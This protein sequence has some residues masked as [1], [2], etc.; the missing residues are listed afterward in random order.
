MPLLFYLPFWIGALWLLIAL[1]RWQSLIKYWQQ[2][3]SRITN[4]IAIGCAIGL[5]IHFS[6]KIGIDAA[7]GL[8]TCTFVLKIVEAR[9]I[10]DGQLIIFIGFLTTSTHFLLLQTIAAAFYALICCGFLISSWRRLYL[11]RNKSMKEIVKRNVSVF[12]QVVPIML[13]LFLLI[14][15]FPPLWTMPGKKTPT[16]GFSEQLS[17]GDLSQLV[18]NYEAAFR[19]SFTTETRPET[20]E[21]Y[22]RGF[23]LDKFDGRTW[24]PT[25]KGSIIKTKKISNMSSSLLSYEI[26][27]EPHGYRWLFSLDRP[28]RIN[29]RQAS[30]GI[31][32]QGLVKSDYIIRERM[33]YQVT[34]DL[35]YSNNYPPANAEPE[36][37]LQLPANGNPQTT[38]MVNSWLQQ[39]LTPE[40]IIN[41]MQKKI[42]RDF[43]YT[44]Q[45]PV[46]S[47]ESID[48]FLF[49]S[50]QGFCEHFASSF[51]FVMR[52]AGI[53]ARVIV[54]YQGGVWNNIE[55]YLLVTQ[56]DA[57][58]WVE[59]WQDKRW[60]RIDPTAFVAPNRIESGIDQALTQADQT[61]LSRRWQESSLLR[62][63]QQRWD[64]AGYTWQ[65]FVLNYDNQYREN[66]LHSLMGKYNPWR[67]MLILLGLVVGGAILLSIILRIRNRSSYP[68]QEKV[69]TLL[70]K[71]LSKRG[72]NRHPGET[73]TA[74][75]KRV[76]TQEPQ[77]RQQL[78]LISRE[79][80]KSI[81]ASTDLNLYQLKKLIRVL[82]T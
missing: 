13:I 70:E 20:K 7:L 61:L 54:G 57:H 2:P 29:S 15:R 65:R 59:V 30:V 33:Q 34:S 82:H 68:E 6:G 50:K 75:C 21:L 45:P 12:L 74:F 78:M 19:V 17:L 52:K 64:A 40:A 31:T 76:A 49:N 4:T 37:N 47:Q 38:A 42:S 53:P 16:T 36:K 24:S 62:E 9:S 18:R 63:L 79:V 48:D 27:F 39:Q 72:Y 32:E 8:L 66:L 67:L 26:I 69:V 51:A 73:T 5:Y 25:D 14:P 11:N 77:L 43:R 10:R 28:M 44:L 56:A 46:L 23:I 81:Y 60:R 80:E 41:E 58:A 3:S 1:W 22:W 55:N 35:Q 71:K